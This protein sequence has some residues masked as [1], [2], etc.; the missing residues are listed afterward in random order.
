MRRMRRNRF[1]WVR[2]ER[3]RFA[4]SRQPP[5]QPEQPDEES[6]PNADAGAGRGDRPRQQ[7]SMDD[8]IRSHLYGGTAFEWQ[9]ERERWSEHELGG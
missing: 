4:I 8:I 7:P 1:H 5:E 9:R 6:P 3:G 2:D